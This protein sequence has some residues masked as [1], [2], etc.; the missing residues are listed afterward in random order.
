[1]IPIVLG[2][3]VAGFLT[4]CIGFLILAIPYVGSVVLLPVS[5]LFRALSVEF[6]EQFGPEY[7]LFPATTSPAPPAPMP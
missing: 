2:I 1:M 5:Y 6:L 4:C 3:I 7:V